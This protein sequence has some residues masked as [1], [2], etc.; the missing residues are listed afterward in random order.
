MKTNNIKYN[1]IFFQKYIGLFLLLFLTPSLLLF[2]KH[3]SEIETSNQLTQAREKSRLELISNTASFH[4]NEFISDVRVLAKSESLNRFINSRKPHLDWVYVAKEFVTMS[5]EKGNYD[6][7]RYLNLSGMEVVRVNYNGGNPTIVPPIELQDKSNRY[8]FKDSLKQNPEH[9]YISPLDLNKEHGIIELPYKPVIRIG[10]TVFNG[11]KKTGVLLLNYYGDKILSHIN[12][13]LSES[14]SETMMVNKN[15]YWLISKDKNNLWGFMHKNNKNLVTTQPDIWNKINSQEKGEI[16]K[17]GYTYLF[18]TIFIASSNDKIS[19]DDNYW[20]IIIK[21]RADKILSPQNPLFYQHLAFHLSFFVASLFFSWLILYYSYQKEYINK[22]TSINHTIFNDI[23]SGII[24]TDSNNRITSINPMVTQ[25]T[26]YEEDEVIGKNPSIFAS[27]NH[28]SD[29]YKD[30]WEQLN[31]N[32]KWSGE[33]WNKTKSGVVFPESLSI[34]TIDDNKNQIQYYI[35]IV[36][37]ISQQKEEEAK[38][39]HKAHYDHLTKLPNRQYFKDYLYNAVININTNKTF[40]LLFIDLDKFK[41]I[42]DTLG[43]DAGD[44]LLI[45]ASRRFLLC[46]RDSDIV[47]RLGGD[48][49]TVLLQNIKYKSDIE[50]VTKKILKQMQMA[51]N[52]CGQESY[53]SVSI[54]I[55][56]FPEDTGDSENLLKKA[57]KAMYKAKKAGRNGY[58]FDH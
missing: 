27:G 10:T 49:F 4:I 43:H 28:N 8:Y 55:A 13:L 38:L 2:T 24:I 50:L 41:E 23:S 31:K 35:A 36:M 7:I 57:D 17:E 39:I 42:N 16:R 33:I 30:M 1:R 20:K 48:E 25:V 6:Q 51:F 11:S 22:L 46:V 26:G 56:I 54:G 32:K 3:K 44:E 53:I 47:A 12:M 34:S 40:A 29:F 14:D 15:G 52:I 18:N 45:E 9:V 21:L 37:D 58:A 5:Q 19:T